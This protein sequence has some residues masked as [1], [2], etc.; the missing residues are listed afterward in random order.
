MMV[1]DRSFS[2]VLLVEALG[3]YS[4]E[5]YRIMK[6]FE[7][8]GFSMSDPHAPTVDE[9]FVGLVEKVG[10]K[11]GLPLMQHIANDMK[12][13]DGLDLRGAMRA[14]NRYVY[15]LEIRRV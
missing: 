2:S 3:E 4:R 11:Q 5:F 13:R 12:E 9:F 15:Y 7:E 14:L 6:S 1:C 8:S 10:V